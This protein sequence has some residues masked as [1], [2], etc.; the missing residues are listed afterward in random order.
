MEK[1]ILG[2]SRPALG[3]AI[4]LVLVA[5][6]CAAALLFFL[7]KYDRCAAPAEP[8]TL[9]LSLR[10]DSARTLRVQL[11]SDSCSADSL[12]MMAYAADSAGRILSD[13]VRAVVPY[14]GPSIPDSVLLGLVL[15][16]AALAACL[17]GLTSLVE[18]VGNDKFVPSWTL[19]YVLR[20]VAGGLLALVF[21]LVARGGVFNDVG[22]RSS[23]E[24]YGVLAVA[25]LIG[26]FSKQAMYKLGDLFDVLFQSNKEDRLKDKLNNAPPVIAGT[27][28]AGLKTGGSG[29]VT[30][31][32]KNF[33]KTSVVR[34]GDVPRAT[35][36]K[37]STEISF[38]L[39][40]ADTAAAGT[41]KLTVVNPGREEKISAVYPL[42]VE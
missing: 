24:L 11:R 27:D 40:A 41:L 14:G 31:K 22:I 20:P 36:Y 18:F 4:Y 6:G 38:V 7:S 9:A 28:P 2:A 3:V 16:T 1:N 30:V 19:W 15:L 21:Y 8:T 17:H 5:V 37:S 10:N 25:G 32:G 35:T 23:G 29:S 42:K 12:P 39:D 13:T 34:V 26:L 33:T